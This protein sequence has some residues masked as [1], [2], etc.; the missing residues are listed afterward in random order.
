[1]KQRPVPHQVNA[2]ALNV[3]ST[4]GVGNNNRVGT[5]SNGDMVEVMGGRD[6]WLTFPFLGEDAWA[7]AR[8]LDEQEVPEVVEQTPAPAVA[9]EEG[10]WW[11][12]AA[13]TL[14][15]WWGAA[16]DAVS[17]AV[18]QGANLIDQGIQQGAALVDQG[19]GL[20]DS[21]LG[22]TGPSDVVAEV[23]KAP[24]LEDAPEGTT[25]ESFMA[26]YSTWLGARAPEIEALQGNARVARVDGLLGQ[27]EQVCKRLNGGTFT[28]IGKLDTKPSGPGAAVEG[29]FVPPELIGV[30]RSLIHIVENDIEGATKSANATVEGSE[31]SNVDW[32]SRLGV[33]TYRNQLDNLASGEVTCNVTSTSMVLERLGYNRQDLIAAVEKQMK[34][35]ILKDE[36]KKVTDENLASVQIDDEKWKTTVKGYLDDVNGDSANY[37][38]IRGQQTTGAK[39]TELAGLYK[40][41]AQ[42]EDILDLLCNLIGVSRYSIVGDPGKVL[43]AIEGDSQ[44]RPNTEQ[45][46][47]WD[48]NATKKLKECL[49]A[50][51]GAILSVKHKGKGKSGTHLISVQSVTSA[52]VVV[53][54]PYGEIRDGYRGNQSGGAYADAGKTRSQS[55]YRNERH[56]N[57]WED[58]KS[59]AAQDMDEGEMRGASVTLE[60]AQ[61]KSMFNRLTLYHRATT[62]DGA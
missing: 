40:E 52:G 62:K 25:R 57:D 33:P 45:F 9:D 53:D 27:V 4:P 42:M 5:L 37:R 19:L 10:S 28:D 49:A 43:K 2:A 29:G 18:D 30:V 17:G 14:S 48:A 32:N 12:G 15:G 1:M 36:G 26:Q 38:R 11:G 34:I 39:R 58:W 20:L 3:R 54:D 47:K 24:A 8:Y 23:D 50:G 44:D 22:G 13:D 56:N 60:N 59:D 61:L 41:N 51:G 46:W 6:G 55:G 7:S 35:K 31:Y 21:W 16:S